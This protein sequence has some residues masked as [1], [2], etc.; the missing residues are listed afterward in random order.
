MQLPPRTSAL[1]CSSM[2]SARQGSQGAHGGSAAR[3]RVHTRA[4]QQAAHIIT[5]HCVYCDPPS[6]AGLVGMVL[7]PR[8]AI[9]A[10]TEQ[11]TPIGERQQALGP[12]LGKPG[13][14][15]ATST[16]SEHGFETLPAT[17]F[18]CSHDF[19]RNMTEQDGTSGNV[20]WRA[21]TVSACSEPVPSCSVLFRAAVFRPVP[22]CSEQ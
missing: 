10:G 8:A 4:P 18:P 13:K 12:T 19:T 3:Y 16:W 11:G 6:R 5:I 17:V 22:S 21:G 7:G 15:P 1:R 2:L 9:S 14:Q 20:G